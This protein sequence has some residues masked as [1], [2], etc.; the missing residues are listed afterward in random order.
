MCMRTSTNHWLTKTFLGWY[1]VEVLASSPPDSLRMYGL[2]P[3]WSF[4]WEPSRLLLV[5]SPSV[6]ANYPGLLLGGFKAVRVLLSKMSVTELFSFFADIVR[7]SSLWDC[8]NVEDVDLR[9]CAEELRVFMS[10]PNYLARWITNQTQFS[11]IYKTVVILCCHMLRSVVGKMS[12]SV[13]LTLETPSFHISGVRG[14]WLALCWQ[15]F[16]WL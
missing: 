4:G 13:V 15:T 12:S 9:F 2:V 8:F 3:D 7:C 16:A 10:M 1:N 6:F 11:V 14:S 5:L